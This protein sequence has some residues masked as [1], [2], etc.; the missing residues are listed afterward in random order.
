VACL[1]DAINQAN[2]NG[3]ANTITLEAGTYS[4]TARNNSTDGFNGLPS[5]TGIVTIQGAGADATVIARDASAPIFRL[6]HVAATGTLT[7]ERLTL[8]GGNGGLGAGGGI[9]NRG[10]VAM[11]RTTITHNTSDTGGGLA[12]NGGTVTIAATT[13]AENGSMHDGGGLLNDGGTVTI[14]QSTFTRNGAE[15]GGGI[16]NRSFSSGNPAGTV[17]LMDSALEDNAGAEAG[18]AVSLTRG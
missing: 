18:G 7:V 17:V 12:T 4:L 11:A 1:I 14:T 15:G 9:F 13:F 3:E 8:S 16:S 6:V 10:T 5:V 2:A